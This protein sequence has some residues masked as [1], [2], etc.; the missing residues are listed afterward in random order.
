MLSNI[1]RHY[2]L[3][4]VGAVVTVIVLKS[5]AHD[6][7]NYYFAAMVGSKGSPIYDNHVNSGAKMERLRGLV[8][9]N[10]GKDF[11]GRSEKLI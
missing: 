2:F 11:L 10:R 5:W 4:T 6:T 9:E 8:V 3:G 7:K 1:F